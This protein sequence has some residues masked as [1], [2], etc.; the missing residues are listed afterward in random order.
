MKNQAIYVRVPGNQPG[1]RIGIVKYPEQGY[2]PSDYDQPEM[3]EEQVQAYVD[4]LNGEMG[5][6]AGVAEA[7]L[8]GS[9]FGWHV[10]AAKPAME[11][12][13]AQ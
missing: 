13:E 7:A 1:E 10:P 9:C 5:V 12:M 3:S 4:L 11:W 2:Y 6:P 8:F